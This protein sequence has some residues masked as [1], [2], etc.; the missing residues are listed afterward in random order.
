MIVQIQNVLLISSTVIPFSL[1]SFS[2]REFSEG[3][4]L[5]FRRLQERMRPGVL[6][7][8]MLANTNAVLGIYG[9]ASQLVVS[10]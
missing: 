3:K 5:R 4:R 9:D 8:N 2:L 6:Y 1:P 10:A 7:A